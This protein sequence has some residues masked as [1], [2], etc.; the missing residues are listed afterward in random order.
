MS[1]MKVH[2]VATGDMFYPD[3]LVTCDARDLAASLEMQHPKLIIEVLSPSTA[4]FDQGDK[5][6]TYRRIEALEEYALVDP[7]GKSFEVYR[8]QTVRSDWLLSEGRADEGSV[9]RSVELTLPFDAVFEN[10]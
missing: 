7:H 4:T 8:R 1:D 5:F 10:A 2:V 9:L 3:V 6:L